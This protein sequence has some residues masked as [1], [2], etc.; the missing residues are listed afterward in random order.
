VSITVLLIYAAMAFFDVYLEPATSMFAAIAIGVGVDFAIHLIDK[1]HEALKLHDEDIHLA[2]DHALPL[3]A[4]ACFF[5]A[6][7]LGLGFA[8]LTTSDLPTLQRFGGLVAL[9][10]LGSY[11]QRPGTGAGPVCLWP[12]ALNSLAFKPGPGVAASPLRWSAVLLAG[13]GAFRRLQG[14]AQSWTG[15]GQSPGASWSARRGTSCGG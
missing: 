6:M 4:R 2:V 8:V 14:R 12:Q 10:S 11:R 3:T 13:R 7:A 15:D 9:A 5:N 1:L